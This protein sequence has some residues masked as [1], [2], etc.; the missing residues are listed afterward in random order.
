MPGHLARRFLSEAD[1]GLLLPY[2]SSTIYLLVRIH[3]C[4][5]S[6]MAG[7]ASLMAGLASLLIHA[8]NLLFR[9]IG[10]VAGVGVVSHDG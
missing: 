4:K 9:A 8:G 5:A 6:L 1:V 2:E 3:R 7:L 10:E